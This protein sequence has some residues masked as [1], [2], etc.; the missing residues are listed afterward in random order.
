[1]KTLTLIRHGMPDFP[2]GQRV[3]LGLTDL[4]LGTLGKLQACLYGGFYDTENVFSS[5]L[6]RAIETAVFI[7][8]DAAI[9]P[10]LQEMSA[11][12]WDGMNF[13]EIREKYPELFA[14]RGTNPATPIPGAEDVFE[15]QERFYKAV[16]AVM[17]KCTGNVAIVAHSTVIG[18]FMCRVLGVPASACR[19]FKLPYL[20][21]YSFNY[22]GEFHLIEKEALPEV[23]LTPDICRELLYA[24][25]LPENIISHCEAVA[26]EAVLIGKALNKKGCNL[27]LE[28]ICHASLLHDIARLSPNHPSA[29]AELINELGFCDIADIIRQH[30]DLDSTDISEAAVV[31]VADKLISGDKKISIADRFSASLPKC[32]TPEAIAAH[33]R[34]QAQA[35]EAAERIE[36][37]LGINLPI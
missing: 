36:N 20:G 3:C 19:R 21:A 2:I 16:K 34:R 14:L 35:Q 25:E 29:G 18:S 11:G 4:P 26:D 9:A 30:H 24:A 10:G 32:T 33:Q 27:N 15:G 37:I 1:M 13:S 22:D 12:E 5:Y 8:P 17:D 6:S 7:S 28:L 23:K 31:Y